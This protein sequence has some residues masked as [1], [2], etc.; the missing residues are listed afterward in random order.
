M[1]Y[2]YAVLPER[3]IVVVPM[4]MAHISTQTFSSEDTMFQTWEVLYLYSLLGILDYQQPQQYDDKWPNIHEYGPIINIQPNPWWHAFF[5]FLFTDTF[6]NVIALGLSKTF[7]HI[8]SSVWFLLF[9]TFI[10]FCS[11]PCFL[12]SFIFIV[13]QYGYHKLFDSLVVFYFLY[14]EN[15]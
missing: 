12:I 6:L 2:T 14:L 15:S 1:P 4:N 9:C 10:I 13:L 5:P 11:F 7:Y 8:G 3:Y